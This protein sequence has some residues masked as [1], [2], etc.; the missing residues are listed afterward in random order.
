MSAGAIIGLILL[1]CVGAMIYVGLPYTQP[2]R[3]AC[4]CGMV[5]LGGAHFYVEPGGSRIHEPD[6]CGPAIEWL[7][8]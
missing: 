2:P 4:C 1:F 7:G 3:N 5:D 6:R 8:A